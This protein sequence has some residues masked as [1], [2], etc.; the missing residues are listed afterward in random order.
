M[1]AGDGEQQALTLR[2]LA[3]ASDFGCFRFFRAEAR[4]VRLSVRQ[5]QLQAKGSE[6]DDR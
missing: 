6:I 2:M 5:R 1:Y 4:S 3:L